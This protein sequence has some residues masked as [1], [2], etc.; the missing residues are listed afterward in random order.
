MF[1]ETITAAKVVKLTTRGGRPTTIVEF[2]FAEIGGVA[3]FPDARR[4]VVS[5]YT[6]RSDVWVVD[7][8]DAE[9]RR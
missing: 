8:F 4:F 6:S 2:P 7:D 3:M 5:V 9:R 1:G